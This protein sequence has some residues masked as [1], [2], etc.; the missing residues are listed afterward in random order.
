MMVNDI[1][2][3]DAKILLVGESPGEE[4]E[5]LG[6]P[7]CGQA[8]LQLKRM[9]S[10]AGIDFNSCYVTNIMSERPPGNR[11]SY[12][13][14]TTKRKIPLAKLTRGIEILKKKI[15]DIKPNI[16]ICLG[17][18]PL[19]AVT[20][21]FGIENWRGS[22]LLVNGTK[23]IPTYHPSYVLRKYEG[24]VICEMDFIKAKKESETSSYT[25]P[26]DNAVFTLAPSFDRTLEWLKNALS[27]KNRVSFDI[28]TASSA[29]SGTGLIRC[30][31]LAQR[32]GERLRTI[33]IPFMKNPNEPGASKV[34]AMR[35]AISVF[36]ESSTFTS[37]WNKNQELQLLKLTNRIFQDEKIQKIGQNS[38]SFDAPRLFDQFKIVVENHYMDTMQAHHCCYLEL[39][40]GLNFLTT[41]YTDFSN[42]WTEKETANDLS[43]WRY[44][45]L[46]SV[47]TLIVSEKL[48]HELK[49]LKVSS[50]YFNHV[51]HLAVA[52]TKAQ[53]IGLLVDVKTRDALRIENEKTLQEIETAVEK[54]AGKKININSPKQLKELFYDQLKFPIQYTKE[55]VIT[56]NENALKTLKKRYPDERVLSEVISH[57]KL[58]KITNTYLKAE[59]SRDAVF[60]TSFDASGTDTGRISSS[61]TIDDTG[62]NL[63]NIP[64][65]LRSLFI[66][67]KSRIFINL[68]LSQAE[69]RVVAECLKRCGYPKL[70]DR[71]RDPSFDV[72]KWAASGI[73]GIREDDVT[74]EQRQIGKLQNHSGNYQA[75]PYVLVSQG[76]K[77]GVQVNGRDINYTDA[78]RILE[79]RHASLPGLKVWWRDIESR[80]A[81]TRT[82]T[83]CLGRKR[84]FFGR[85]DNTLLRVATAFEPQSTIGDV[86]NQIFWKHSEQLPEGARTLNQVHDSILVEC[87]IHQIGL[88]VEMMKRLSQIPLFVSDEPI[89]V[90]ID[91]SVGYNWKDLTDYNEWD[92][93]VKTLKGRNN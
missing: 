41:M 10:H 9:L 30:L 76:L 83:T 26:C 1:G 24:H 88:V 85:V 63:Q 20:N 13:Y 72:H 11:F 25:D 79:A 48:D 62:G 66:P 45:C 37:Y 80:I 43:E 55:G 59:L 52:L 90:P 38:I 8:G 34:T 61:K 69:A 54:I 18:E 47:V 77:R 46:D 87:F 2:P 3:P 60:F 82:I 21:K 91:I 78:K 33:S 58:A 29:E 4:E 23:I 68:D 93:D 19:R 86:C 92:K 39:P 35:T 16:V 53:R 5:R 36:P 57:R 70:S 84:F 65:K 56:T 31:G 73:Y 49:E 40:K 50:L 81:S 44:N 64:I 74:Y 71:F 51:H 28:E 27:C 6:K 22:V 75:G 7:F 15:K 12:F 14:E 32:R 42:Y 89:I 17:A 67:R